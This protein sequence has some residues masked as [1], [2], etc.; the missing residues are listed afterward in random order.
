MFLSDMAV[1]RPVVA[2]VLSL[3]LTL[4]GLVA[5]EQL[6]LRQYPDIDP[7]VVSVRTVYPGASANIVETRVTELLEERISGVEGIDT[8]ESVS[9]DGSSAITITFLT[10]R[11]IDAAAND[12]R[13]RVA[14]ILDDLP[15]EAEAP[16]IGKEDAD[17]DVMLWLNLISDRMTVPELT[18][19]ARRYL[20]DRF[21]VLPG[22]A[23]IRVGG[24]QNFAMR[25]WLDRRQMTARG[26]TSQDI[27]AKLRGNNVELPAGSLESSSRQFTVRLDRSFQAATDFEQLVLAEG[28]DGYLVRL[29]DVARV[30]FGT[31]EDRSAFRGNGVPQVGLG[32]IRQSTANTLDVARAAKA[33]GEKINPTLPEGMEITLSYDTSVFV[34]GAIREVYKT[35]AIAIGFVIVVIFIFLGSAR[36]VLVPAVAVPVSIIGTCLAIWVLGFTINLLTLLALVLVIGLVV[37][38]AIVVL[39][40]IVRRMNEYGETPLVAA[41]EGTRQV[42]FAVIATTIVLISVFVPVAFLQSDVG[43]LFSE[44]ALTIAAAVAISSFVALTLSPVIASKFLRART[45]GGSGS[46]GRLLD[47]ALGVVRGFY[48]KVLDGVLA[49]PLIG[50]AL[51]GASIGGAYALHQQLPTEFAPREDRGA[52][53]VIVR[54]PEGASYDYMTQYM[55]EI[56]RRL[57]PYAD[58]GVFQ[59]LLIRA[60]ASRGGNAENFNSG[61]VIVVLDDWAK[62]KPAWP[63]MNEVRGKLASLSGVR[64]FPIMR[65]GFGGRTT[66]PIQ[67]TIG[68]GSWEQ[69]VQWRRTLT[70]AIDARGLALTGI[71]WDYKETRPE[72][73]VEVDYDRSAELGVSINGIGRTLETMLGSRRV[74]SFLFDGE[75][76]DVILE[77][78]RDAQRT[79]NNLQN[80]YVRSEATQSLIPLSNLVSLTEKGGSGALNRFNRIRAITLEANL[81]D[82][83]ILG[84]SLAELEALAREV[85]PEEVVIDFK[86]QSRDLKESSDS[87][88]FVFAFGVMVVFLVLAAQFESWRHPFVIMLSVPAALAGGL[89]SLWFAG[90][91]LN[92]Y[93]QIGL[94]MLVGLAAKN[95]ILIVEFAN[96]LRDAGRPFKEALRE[97]ALVRFRPI[98]MTG[99]TTAAGS[100]PLLLSSGPGSET[101]MV[102]GLV[103]LGGVVTS[104]IVTL[105][106]VPAAYALIAKGSTSP[107]AVA[108]QLERERQAHASAQAAQPGD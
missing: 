17:Q 79:P 18:D 93:S 20:N 23:R 85:L 62:R 51:I 77:G 6:P 22:V 105:I 54:G 91:S 43:R 32:I 89:A 80:I 31:E 25:I 94:I 78:E 39:E 66:K 55:D 59:R 24:Q 107:G 73:R 42:S 48:A 65:Q 46:F 58:S 81:P 70:D 56:E 15:P 27:E 95:G 82:G 100:V 96:Q 108:A 38:D 1:K 103:I 75:E 68:G 13:D 74:T 29:G 87:I 63:I 76:Y 19:Y 57:M 99:I 41:Y 40:N 64:A 101:R 67:M 45:D 69:L 44:F 102:I 4:C 11:D 34:E 9:R 49:V 60:P 92:L 12:I 7:P 47:R 97:A 35:L 33:L 3:V 72:L 53:F 28:D 8:V 2:T 83:Q 14:G 21:S 98:V 26:I 30:E 86:G 36:S 71:D 5:F 10:S 84:E 88:L 90:A 106:T 52:F 16:D 50:V 61:I 104:T 37:D